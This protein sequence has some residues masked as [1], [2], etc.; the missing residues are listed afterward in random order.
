MYAIRSYYVVA[1]SQFRNYASV[2]GVQIDL[3]VQD[4]RQKASRGRSPLGEH[5]RV[6]ERNA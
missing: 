6:V 4:M 5:A 2:G 3:R 1:R